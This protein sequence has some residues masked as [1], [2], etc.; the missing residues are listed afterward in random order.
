[1]L[2]LYSAGVERGKEELI[3]KHDVY[4]RIITAHFKNTSSYEEAYLAVK[5]EISRHPRSV[6]DR[7]KNIMAS[8][9][10]DSITA[11]LAAHYP[12]LTNV[13]KQAFL[14]TY[15]T[16]DMG[17]R[18]MTYL[19]SETETNLCQGTPL[20]PL[21]EPEGE[22]IV[23]STQENTVLPKYSN[24]LISNVTLVNGRDASTMTPEDFYALIEK[25]NSR[26]DGLEKLGVDKSA[27]V[28]AE[29]ERLKKEIGD[30]VE[31]MDTLFTTAM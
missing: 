28:K 29:I 21:G 3:Y 31:L 8:V 4:H 23:N 7:T 1:M 22:T 13:V 26:I 27:H 2:K 14:E 24:D 17:R 15:N 30:L 20:K 25:L 18:V 16:T 6:S 11:P 9:I 10:W 5:R 19:R 12:R